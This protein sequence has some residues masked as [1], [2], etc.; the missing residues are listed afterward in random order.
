M[1]DPIANQPSEVYGVF[2]GGGV[3]GTA[4]VGAL[5]AIEEAGL[6]FR[7]VAGTSQTPEE[8]RKMVEEGRVDGRN[9]L[10]NLGTAFIRFAGPRELTMGDR[11]DTLLH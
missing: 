10:R 9:V 1:T 2:E 5:A 11:G 8:R 3:K 7:A 4:L 6:Q